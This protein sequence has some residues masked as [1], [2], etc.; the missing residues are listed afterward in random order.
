MPCSKDVEVKLIVN[1]QTRKILGGQVVSGVP[2]TDKV[3]Q[4]TM[5]I[6]YGITVDQFVHLSYSSQPYQSFYPANNLTIAC[7]EDAISKLK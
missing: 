2:V 5:A 4:I 6:Q 3:D 7:V 1:K